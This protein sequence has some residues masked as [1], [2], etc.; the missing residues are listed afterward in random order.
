MNTSGGNIGPKS[1]ETYVVYD[2]DTGEIHHVH[3]VVTF[4]GAEGGRRDAESQARSFV[5]KRL[6]FAQNLKVLPIPN[7]ALR[8]GIIHAVDVNT[9]A[10]IVKERLKFSVRK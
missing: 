2:G 7:D 8:P 10:L 9:K 5:E 4:E 6:A 3:Q 1:I